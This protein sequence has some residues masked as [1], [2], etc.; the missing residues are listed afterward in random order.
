LG[1]ETELVLPANVTVIGNYAFIS[2]GITS[3]TLHEGITEIGKYAFAD[4]IGLTE[5]TLPESLEKIGE[6]AFNSCS[7][8]S[9]VLIPENVTSI[10]Y[11]AFYY[12]ADDLVIVTPIES[13]PYG[14]SSSAWSSSTLVI[15]GYSG[16]E[17][18]YT[19]VTNCDQTVADVT[20]AL[21]VAMPE[22][23]PIDGMYFCGWYD[24][25]EFSG[26]AI[27][28][29]YY[30]ATKT[31]LYAKWL[32]QEQYEM[33]V[34]AGTSFEYAINLAPGSTYNVI[35]D[36]GG[37]RVYFAFTATEAG[38]YTFYGN[39]SGDTY[40]H[41]YS[42]ANGSDETTSDDD[43]PGSHFQFW[44]DLDAGETVYFAVRYWSSSNTGTFQVCFEVDG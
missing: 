20:T 9:F 14:W 43:G 30:S 27:S 26:S 28:G 16:A 23:A 11:S 31:T 12:M 21:T 42:D 19:F 18:T 1:N 17:N 2:S 10:G 5:I 36:E 35:I 41:M 44:F 8:I 29:N 13:K 15:Y 34:L 37:E 7:G 22:L 32:T 33:E 40:G 39:G 24:N 4:C 38:S 3:V 25:A 6:D